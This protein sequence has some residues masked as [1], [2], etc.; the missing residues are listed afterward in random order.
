MIIFIFIRQKS[1]SN[2][3]L[4]MKSELSGIIGGRSGGRTAPGDTLQGGDTRRKKIWV[5][6]YKE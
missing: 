2:S 4:E 3:S 6:I 1:I 5:Q